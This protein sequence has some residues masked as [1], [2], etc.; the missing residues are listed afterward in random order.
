MLEDAKPIHLVVLCDDRDP[1]PVVNAGTLY[2]EHDMA[3]KKAL[4]LRIDSSVLDALHKWTSDDLRSA[5]AQM[6]FLLRK[7]LREAGRL[8]AIGAGSPSRASPKKRS[9]ARPTLRDK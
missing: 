2:Q 3:G 9:T 8:P 7:G 5:N 1:Q 6:E 4:L